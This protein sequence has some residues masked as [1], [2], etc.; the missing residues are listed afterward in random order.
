MQ[1]DSSLFN[2]VNT[3]SELMDLLRPI[4]CLRKIFVKLYNNEGTIFLKFTNLINVHET[5]DTLF[6]MVFDS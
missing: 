6:I 2:L 4:I 1:N 3:I 5:H